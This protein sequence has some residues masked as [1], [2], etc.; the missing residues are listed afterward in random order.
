MVEPSITVESTWPEATLLARLRASLDQAD[1]A[2]L[3]VAF[4]NLKGVGLLH[5]QLRRLGGSTRLLVTTGFADVSPALNEVAGLGAAIRV[6]NLPG[7]TY[8]PKLY[9]TRGA[10]GGAAMVGS[11]NLIGGLVANI[12]TSLVVQGDISASVALGCLAAR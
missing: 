12:E 4:V 9:L 2:L 8:H 3:C 7:G 1:E 5:R 6:F 11:A 10:G